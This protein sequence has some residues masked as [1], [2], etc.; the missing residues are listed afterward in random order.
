MK[1]IELLAPAGSMESLNSAINA[2]ANAIYL[3]GSAFGARKTAGFSNEELKIAVEIC[4]RNGVSLYVTVNTLIKEDELLACIEFV[5]FLYEIKVDALILQDFGLMCAIKK[6]YPDFEC[7]ASTQMTLHSVSDVIYAAKLGFS[8]VVLAREVSLKEIMAI[9]S[10]TDI[11]LEVFVHGALCI[12]YSGNCLMSSMIGG[13]SGNRGSCAQ[14]C[15]KRYTLKDYSTGEILSEKKQVYLLSP[16]DLFAIDQIELFKKIGNVS[17]KIE[18]RL[19]GVDY[20]YNVVSHYRSAIDGCLKSTADL[21]KSFNRQFTVGHLIGVPYSELMNYD[22]PSGYGTILGKVKHYDHSTAEIILFD[23]LNKGDEIQNRINGNTTG[24]RTDIIYK[25]NKKVESAEKGDVV[26]IIYKMPLK[27]NSILYKTY[28]KVFID[29][30]TRQGKIQYPKFGVRFK[31][32]AYIGNQALLKAQLSQSSD[33]ETF[34]ANIILEEVKCTSMHPVEEARSL[35][36]DETR[37]AEQLSKLGGTAYYLEDLS[38]DIDEKI[39]LPISE[40]NRM[41]REVIAMIDDQL[42]N[43]YPKRT[44]EIKFKDPIKKALMG[45]VDVDLCLNEQNSNERKPKRLETYRFHVMNRDQLELLIQFKETFKNPCE[46]EIIYHDLKH[47]MNILEYC[48]EQQVIPALPKIMGKTEIQMISA[49]LERYFNAHA[50]DTDVKRMISIAHIAHQQLLSQYPNAEIIFEEDAMLFNSLSMRS[51]AFENLAFSHE[52]TLDES[53]KIMANIEPQTKQYQ[54]FVYGRF[55]V[56]T[57]EY[58]VVGG[59]LEGHDHCGHCL[60]QTFVLEDEM[61]EIYPLV[62]EPTVCRMQILLPKPIYLLDELTTLKDNDILHYKI[63]FLGS[64]LRE[65]TEVLNQISRKTFSF[66]RDQHSRGHY[67]KAIE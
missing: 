13:R 17:L 11:E 56:M 40:L 61:K 48:I 21:S 30:M 55:P 5:D 53:K 7:H 66:N 42:I 26:K 57:S 64:T 12:S 63:S 62:L 35:A 3:G 39:A 6:R 37:V 16:K 8:R 15:R 51:L 1:N 4:H 25:G 10:A 49:F 2:G 24:T 22:L 34:K 33:V 19:K 54:W 60:K 44:H 9:R 23:T 52:V 47:Y 45:L 32:E 29:K 50:L 36:L 58:C 59:V 18:G 65:V 43:R 38:I 41:R 14:P 27:K 46:I 20:V 31:F 28:D 67:K